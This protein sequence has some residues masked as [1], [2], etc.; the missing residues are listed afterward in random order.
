M[1]AGDDFGGELSI[2][3]MLLCDGAQVVGGKLYVLGGGWDRLAFPEYP[4]TI[5]VGVAMGVRVPWTETNRQHSFSIRALTS[6]ADRELFQ[7]AGGFE[8]GRPPGTPHGM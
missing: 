4:Q 1:S 3:Y 2:D 5:P 8:M 7:L 6:D